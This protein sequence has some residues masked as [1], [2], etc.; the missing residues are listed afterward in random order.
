M[1]TLAAAAGAKAAQGSTAMCFVA[2][3]T[4]EALALRRD[5]TEMHAANDSRQGHLPSDSA[6]KQAQPVYM[7]TVVMFLLW[8]RAQALIAA[9]SP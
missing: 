6:T 5:V 8:F 7:S 2:V 4:P 1:L 3:W 9:D